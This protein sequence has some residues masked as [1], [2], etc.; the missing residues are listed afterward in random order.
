[1]L[2]DDHRYPPGTLYNQLSVV[3]LVPLMGSFIEVESRQDVEFMTTPTI[4][5]QDWQ[6][7]QIFL[8]DG[9]LEKG[10]RTTVKVFDEGNAEREVFIIPS[11]ATFKKAQDDANP[12]I[13]VKTKIAAFL[14]VYK[15]GLVPTALGGVE[16]S[17]LGFDFVMDLLESC[18]VLH[19][20]ADGGEPEI[21]YQCSCKDFWHYYKC[22]HS[23]GLSIRKKNVAI[24]DIYNIKNI[25]RAAKRGRPKK[26]KRGAALDVDR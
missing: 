4:T 23:L 6:Q 8:E 22:R 13:Y 2:F 16:A 15:S 11:F 9:Q 24:P 7:A 12:A 19:E 1:M 18:Y 26:T 14:K 17:V 21:K 3:A 20:L 25:G 10:F 5:L